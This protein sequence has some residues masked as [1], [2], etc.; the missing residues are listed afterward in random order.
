M[1]L[2]RFVFQAFEST[3]YSQRSDTHRELCKISESA[4]ILT[5]L[6]STAITSSMIDSIV[7]MPLTGA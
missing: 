2:A 4:A 5:S 6:N 7:A 1:A 3:V